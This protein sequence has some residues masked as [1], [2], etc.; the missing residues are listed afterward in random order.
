MEEE[1]TKS[2]NAG[3]LLPA[4]IIAAG[5]MIAVAV[6][7]TAGGRPEVARNGATGA[8]A[9]GLKPETLRG[10]N[11]PFLGDPGAP[12]E[13]IEFSDFQCPFCERFFQAVEPQIINEY[14]KTG[15][16]KFVYRNFAFLGAESVRAAEA[17]ECAADQGKFWEYHDYLFNQQSG[18]NQGAFADAKLKQFARAVGLDG[19]LFDSCLDGGKHKNEVERDLEDG[20]NAGVTGTPATFVNGKMISGVSSTRPYDPFKQAIDE[21]LRSA[22]K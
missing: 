10:D 20:R 8:A 19:A 15:K 7:Y 4:A 13:V 9:V 22:G 16:V 11:E 18:E 2:E 5:V 12:V 17:A 6:L 21:A 14:V 1:K 3:W